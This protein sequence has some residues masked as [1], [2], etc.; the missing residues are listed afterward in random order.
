MDEE[1]IPSCS[2]LASVFINMIPHFFLTLITPNS[3]CDILLWINKLQFIQKILD[4]EES[5]QGKE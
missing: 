1:K 4:F 5:F 2:N 3:T